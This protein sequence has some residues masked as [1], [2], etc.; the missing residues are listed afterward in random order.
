MLRKL[1]ALGILAAA[2]AAQGLPSAAGRSKVVQYG[3]QQQLSAGSI[4]L[5][6]ERLA[7]P[8]FAQSVILIVQYDPDEG[9]VG[10]IINRRTELPLSR[11]FPDIKQA[12]SDPAYMGGP[13]EIAAIQALLRLPQKTDQATRVADNVY[14]TGTKDL[15]EKSIASR[16]EPSDFRI[17]LGYAGWASRQLEAEIR[18]G[19]WSVLNHRSNLVFD[20]N[21]GSLWSRLT[22]ESH[23]QVAK[24]TRIAKRP[25][26]RRAGLEW[27]A[28]RWPA[29]RLHPA[30]Q[31]RRGTL[32]D[33][34]G[35]G[36]E[37]GIERLAAWREKQEPGRPAGRR[38]P[39]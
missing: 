30:R 19:A 37:L 25:S 16:A 5:A 21:P 27:R 20:K 6:S 10:L 31:P 35:S 18:L 1:A 36:P 23:T 17:Y 34:E 4:L 8:N 7:D 32:S 39:G 12:S 38:L 26:D 28:L 14:L 24:L 11:L 15:I 9:T 22:R 3:S 33:P 2:L 13:V 29:A